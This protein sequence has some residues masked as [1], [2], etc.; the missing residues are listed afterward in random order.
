M[1]IVGLLTQEPLARLAIKNKI[2]NF[3]TPD[4][5]R[6]L[7]DFIKDNPTFEDFKR[8]AKFNDS[9]KRALNWGSDNISEEEYQQIISELKVELEEKM[10]LQKDRISTVTANGKEVSTF[11][12]DDGSVIAIDNSYGKKPISEQLEEI[13]SKYS[14]FRQGEATNTE[15]IIEYMEEEV[16]PENEFQ[17]VATV[18]STSLSSEEEEMAAVAKSYQANSDNQVSIDF[19]NR[20]L[21]DDGQVL[22]MEKTE[23]GY[24]VGA[25]EAVN[26]QQEASIEEAPTMEKAKQKTLTRKPYKQAGFSSAILLALI[27]GMFM[28][29]IILNLYIKTI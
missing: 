7:E 14:R 21:L 10:K 25:A 23:N 2:K 13:Q 27:A 5:Y 15:E 16:K 28:G 18:T 9:Y 19:E 20:L 4:L 24:V 29:L 17:D 22:E 3:I 6:D 8:R 1:E 12:K 26:E 11:Q